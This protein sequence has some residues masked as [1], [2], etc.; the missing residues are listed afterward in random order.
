M[1]AVRPVRACGATV[2]KIITLVDW[3]EG[4]AQ[5]LGKEGIEPVALFIRRAI[6]SDERRVLQRAD[7]FRPMFHRGCCED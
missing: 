2:K 5:N 4:A 1:Q 6:C 7:A 3:L